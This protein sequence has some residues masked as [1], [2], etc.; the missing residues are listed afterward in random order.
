MLLRN[1]LLASTL[2]MSL[3]SF[4][5][6][7]AQTSDP[8]W[9][10]PYIGI[11]GGAT[12][13]HGLVGTSGAQTNNANALINAARPSGVILKRDGSEGGVQSGYNYQY[14][15]FVGGLEADISALDADASRTYQGVTPA[16]G[17]QNSYL[18]EKIEDLGTVRARLGYLITPRVLI[19]G[20][21]GYAYGDVKYGAAL[22][23]PGGALAFNGAEH[24]TAGGYAAGAGVE[25]AYPSNLN[26]LGHS[27]AVTFR[28]EYLHY[29]LG[30][31]AVNV[32][33]VAGVGTGG[34]VS[35]FDTQGDLVR[36][37]INFKF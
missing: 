35:S 17:L 4:A 1:I 37:G 10:G 34:Y 14:G 32:A 20:T 33:A 2:A 11:Q 15:R 29:D 21:G 12:I 26:M 24:Y 7:D 9:T 22:A 6:A 25:Y 18:S 23:N 16:G 28:L 5:Q 27:S 19:Y 3:V 36:A 30:R 13:D 8:T 31:K